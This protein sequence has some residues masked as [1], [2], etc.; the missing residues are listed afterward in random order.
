MFSVSFLH[1]YVHHTQTSA[2]NTKYESW[3]ARLTISAIAQIHNHEILMSVSIGDLLWG[4]QDPVLNQL[5]QLI[6]DDV[7]TSDMFGLLMG[8]GIYLGKRMGSI[9]FKGV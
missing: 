6:G 2:V 9:V 7:I 4:Y 5:Q 8:V 1:L 3:M